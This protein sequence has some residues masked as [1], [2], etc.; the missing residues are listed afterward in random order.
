ML[1]SV[2]RFKV[3]WAID[4]PQLIFMS[5]A[6]DSRDLRDKIYALGLINNYPSYGVIPVYNMS[7]NNLFQTTS[8]SIL[9]EDGGLGL[10]FS[11]MAYE[12]DPSKRRTGLPS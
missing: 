11:N 6:H 12:R 3:E 2:H 9:E 7:M 8:K 5:A 4:L 1:H 10:G